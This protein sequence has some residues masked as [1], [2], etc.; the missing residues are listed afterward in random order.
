M[1]KNISI[2]ARKSIINRFSEKII[3]KKFMSIITK[4]TN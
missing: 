3:Y 2:E 4:N 1:T